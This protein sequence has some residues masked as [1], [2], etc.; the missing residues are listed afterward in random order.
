MKPGRGNPAVE[1]MLRDANDA[2]S[3]ELLDI[4]DA[5]AKERAWQKAN[6]G[7][8]WEVKPSERTGAVSVYGL[9]IYPITLYANQWLEL[10]KSENVA[11]IKRVIL[12]GMQDGTVKIEKESKRGQRK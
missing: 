12:K 6:Y 11:R 2:V 9:R 10:L 7:K 3:Q 8:V 5:R 1:R 4:L